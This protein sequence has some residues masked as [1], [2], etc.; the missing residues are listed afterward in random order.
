MFSAAALAFAACS[1]DEDVKMPA[2]DNGAKTISVA[3]S[4]S[5]TRAAMTP[6]A[7][8][9]TEAA[10]SKLD[11]YFTDAT[12]AVKY[13]YSAAESGDNATQFTTLTSGTPVR[14]VGLEDVS[15]VYIIANDAN[16]ALSVGG[17]V[18]SYIAKLADN[19]A[20]KAESAIAYVGGDKTLDAGTEPAEGV[21]EENDVIV[22]SPEGVEYVYAKVAIRPVISRLEI[23]NIAVQTSGEA[24]L[25]VG[26]GDAGKKYVVTWSGFNPTIVGM[27][28][29]NVYDQV[30]SVPATLGTLFA[31]PSD[32]GAI[33]KGAWTD[34]NF[35]GQGIGAYSNYAEGTGY[36]ALFADA[37]TV[38]GDLTYA[39][40]GNNTCVPFNFLVPFD[41]TS[42]NTMAGSLEASA[43]MQQPQFHVQLLKPTADWN[44]T[45]NVYN[46][47]DGDGVYDE[48]TDTE[49]ADPSLKA[50]LIIDY[51][52]P[53]VTV[54]GE[55]NTAFANFSLDGV[56]VKPATI[57]Q[58]ETLTINPFNV[59]ATTKYISTKNVIV[60]VT[61][62]D[63]GTVAVTPSFDK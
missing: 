57:Y 46:D 59:T 47:V 12:G 18:N 31:T 6:D 1:N 62:V 48:G 45:V 63:Y 16:A 2:S 35:L 52:Y 23:E 41:V 7:P 56:T 39:F 30:T 32:A 38:E 13:V 54:D 3:I 44:Y 8:Y 34:T 14:F 37:A 19:H 61:P 21:S 27:Y 4:G 28:M 24:P 55:E 20:G 15:A 11:I 22:G 42:T 58:M 60:A 5:M 51:T 9:A 53:T 43:T 49:V 50:S 17:N 10:L 26:Q 25:V 40:K 33:Q 36:A 29:S